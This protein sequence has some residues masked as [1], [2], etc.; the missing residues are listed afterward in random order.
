MIELGRAVDA[1]W[2]WQQHDRAP[3]LLPANAIFDA[4]THEI[5]RQGARP[6]LLGGA[7]DAGKVFVD[8]PGGVCP[9]IEWRGLPD[10]ITP[11]VDTLKVASATASKIMRGGLSTAS[12]DFVSAEPPL[13][14]VNGN[15]TAPKPVSPVTTDPTTLAALLLRQSELAAD[16]TPEGEAEYQKVVAQI[17]A[18]Q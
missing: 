2:S 14:A 6:R 18:L 13:V 9:R 4:L 11:L 7:D 15:G 12:L 10:Q 5:Y 16:V 8:F 3:C 1:A 17:A